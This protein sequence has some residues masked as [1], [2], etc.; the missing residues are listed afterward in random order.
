MSF[1]RGWRARRSAAQYRAAISKHGTSDY[2][3]WI[4]RKREIERRALQG[5]PP[6]ITEP[7]QYRETAEEAKARRERD[8]I[9][10]RTS[11]DDL[12]AEA[13]VHQNIEPKKLN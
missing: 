10:L 9:L 6:L 13:E 4:T 5:L 8:S 3:E 7:E 11:I 1:D 2:R 12:E